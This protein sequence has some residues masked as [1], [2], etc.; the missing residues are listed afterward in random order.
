LQILEKKLGMREN[1][2]VSD[3]LSLQR[4]VFS[5]SGQ[6]LAAV[7]ENFRFFWTNREIASD[8]HLSAN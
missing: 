2:I 1:V 8:Q 5:G 4:A 7:Q 6:H 3:V